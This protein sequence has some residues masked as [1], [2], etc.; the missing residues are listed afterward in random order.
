MPPNPDHKRLGSGAKSKVKLM[1]VST[2]DL[3]TGEGDAYDQVAARVFES[4][5]DYTRRANGIFEGYYNGSLYGCPHVSVIYKWRPGARNGEVTIWNYQFCGGNMSN[6]IET[7][8]PG[9]EDIDNV[10]RTLG[11]VA[12]RARNYGS[13]QI[14]DNKYLF[15]GVA[16]R[17]E[18]NCG[19]EIRVFEGLE[20]K[21]RTARN[22]CE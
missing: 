19:V 22:G 2:Q 9:F 8:Q 5:N 10:E 15:R 17:N 11:E 14:E 4:R 21:G 12:T 7:L 18:I 1:R 13:G 6:K 20:M 16:L 3:F